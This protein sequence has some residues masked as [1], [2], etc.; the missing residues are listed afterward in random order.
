MLAYK[1][2]DSAQGLSSFFPL[3]SLFSFLNKM[4]NHRSSLEVLQAPLE[5][6]KTKWNNENVF[7]RKVYPPRVRIKSMLSHKTVRGLTHYAS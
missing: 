1:F 5:K 2:K 3:S 6:N 7:W 4:E